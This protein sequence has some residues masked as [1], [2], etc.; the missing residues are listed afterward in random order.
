MAKNSVLQALKKA[1]AGLVFPSET[2]APFEAFAWEGEEGKPDK[3][4]VLERAGSPANKPVTAK[5]LDAFFADATREEDWHNQEEKEQ[6][7]RF[8][9]LVQALKDSLADVK[10]FLV[11]PKTE[12]HA[13]IVGRVADDG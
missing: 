7:A 6:V 8:R 4:R 9:Q 2:D 10:V 5:S 3:A 12:R 11:G 1:S 13:Y